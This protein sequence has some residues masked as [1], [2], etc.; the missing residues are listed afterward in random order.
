MEQNTC[1][2]GMHNDGCGHPI[3]CKTP[4]LQPE[5][6]DYSGKDCREKHGFGDGL[7]YCTKTRGHGEDHECH[8]Y[9]NW[10]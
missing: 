7:A 8:L 5:H 10:Q 3:P 9:H 4:C 1:T 2:N 6:I